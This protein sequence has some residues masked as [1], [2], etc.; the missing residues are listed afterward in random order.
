MTE[1][2]AKPL[3][4][5]QIADMPLVWGGYIIRPDDEKFSSYRGFPNE[6]GIYGMYTK[7]QDLIYI[8]RSVAIASRLRQHAR[9]T[10]FQGG[11]PSFY[12]YRLVPECAIM[13]VEVAHIKALGPRENQFM[14]VGGCLLREPMTPA[15]A[16]VWRDALPVQR[17]RVDARY[18]E[19]MEQIAARL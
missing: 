16:H 3:T 18:S 5:H 9:R 15:V 8:G 14:E 12:S 17:A 19:M 1:R 4:L 7:D 11:D 6:P 2:D 13:A 10:F